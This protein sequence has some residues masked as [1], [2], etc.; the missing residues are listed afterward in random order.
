MTKYES[1]GY[2]FISILLIILIVIS[3]NPIVYTGNQNQ[4]SIIISPLDG[5]TGA[6]EVIDY[7]NH[8]VHSGSH[9]N[10]RD[11]YT[12][13]KNSEKDF[14]IVTPNSTKFAHLIFGLE[15]ITS[16]VTFN[17][18]ENCTVSDNGTLEPVR[19][20]NRNFDNGNL[21]LLYEDPTITNNGNEIASG[22]FGAGRNSNGGG[23]RDTEEIILRR[24]ET[25]CIL[26]TE[27]NVATTSVNILF[28][29]YE[30]TD[31]N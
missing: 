6:L 18:F 13:T 28:D 30:H 14:L 26:I 7:A 17:I 25:Y 21:V 16:T 8:E 24:D 3:S 12:I 23:G 2:F 11:Y 10:Y 29:W 9:Y 1:W 15:S 4:S 27:L 5:S 20:R 31:K 22:I 19:N